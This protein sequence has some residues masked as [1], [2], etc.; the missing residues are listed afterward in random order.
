MLTTADKIPAR[1][2]NIAL[3]DWDRLDCGNIVVFVFSDVRPL[4]GAA[5]LLDWRLCGQISRLLTSR[6]FSGE[7]DEDAVLLPVRGRLGTRRIFVLGMGSAA[8]CNEQAMADA[9]SRGHEVVAQAGGGASLWTAPHSPYHPDCAH[10]FAQA[11]VT[12][13]LEAIEVLLDPKALAL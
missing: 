8:A 2:R 10:R 1:I 7:A 3:R 5:G 9:I 6:T 11:V 13:K 12:R 4:A